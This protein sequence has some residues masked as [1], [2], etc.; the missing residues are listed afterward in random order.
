ML[1]SRATSSQQL[2]KPERERRFILR[3]LLVSW[4]QY[5][6]LLSAP[7]HDISVT[8]PTS[9]S[10]LV[11]LPESLRANWR[12]L[13]WFISALFTCL[14]FKLISIACGVEQALNSFWEGHRSQRKE[15]PGPVLLPPPLLNG[16]TL[17]QRLKINL[18]NIVILHRKISP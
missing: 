5:Y 4:P 12:R 17:Y 3:V 16:S 14:N 2:P 6:L 11:P 15:S 7:N 18:H 9:P 1:W 13:C 10:I 8:R